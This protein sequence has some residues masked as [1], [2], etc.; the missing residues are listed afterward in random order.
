MINQQKSFPKSRLPKS[1]TIPEIVRKRLEQIWKQA[2]NAKNEEDLKKLY[3]R[4]AASYDEDHQAVGF[5]GHFTASQLL[6]RHLG[7]TETAKIL[8]AGAGTGAAGMALASLG[9]KTIIGV[10]LS[11][12]MLEIASRK[13]VYQELHSLD[14]G[15]PLDPWLADTFDAAILVGV[16]SYG[17]APAHALDEVLR[18]VRPGGLMV[19]TMRSDFFES[20]AMGVKS[21]LNE[22]EEKGAWELVELTEPELYLPNKDQEATFQVWCYRVLPGKAPAID[23]DF[24]QTARAILTK[25]ASIKRFDHRYIWN[26]SGSRLYDRYI[27]T[28]PYYLNVCE[29]EILQNNAPEILGD[30]RVIVELG[31]GSARK[32]SYLLRVVDEATESLEV[33][34]IPIDL[35]PAALEQTQSSIEAKLGDTVSVD[36]IHAPFDQALPQIKEHQNKLLLFFGSSIGNLETL[37]ETID[38]LKMVRKNMHSG[39]RLV[40]GIDLHKDEE[41]LRQAYQS[42]DENRL[43][44][45]NIVRRL[46]DE[47]GGTFDLSAFEQRS[48]Y[49]QHESYEG[50]ENRCVN[51]KLA[52]KV[53]QTVRLKKIDLEVTLHA[54]DCIQVGTSRKYR[55]EDIRQLAADSGLELRRQWLDQRG[56]FSLNELVP[57]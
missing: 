29:E 14:L 55:P 49:D 48:T 15:I 17:Q 22:L 41:V 12:E 1:S 31:C 10:D 6:A 36:P 51:F 9:Y 34:Y 43:F 23:H 19:F 5:F 39:D 25:P 45:L 8:D 30:E 21:K 54:G 24:A 28:K 37:K 3:A 56:Y 44:F 42:G 11:Q 47:L 13:G 40:V 33:T 50:V 18:V 4:W 27:E 20:D 38:F 26:S 7:Q 2:Y 32:V 16:F 52:T 35:S 53:A 57:V 46:N